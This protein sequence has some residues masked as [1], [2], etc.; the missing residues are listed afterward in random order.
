MLNWTLDD[1]DTA[2]EQTITTPKGV[3]FSISNRLAN[4][5]S[6]KR[7]R[8]A[9]VAA[10]HRFRNRRIRKNKRRGRNRTREQRHDRKCRTSPCKSLN[11]GGRRSVRNAHKDFRVCQMDDFR[12]IFFDT[13]SCPTS[14]DRASCTSSSTGTLGATE[15]IVTMRAKAVVQILAPA[16]LSLGGAA[17]EFVTFADTSVTHLV[18]PLR[19][20]CMGRSGPQSDAVDDSAHRCLR[21]PLQLC[22]GWNGIDGESSTGPV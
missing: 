22:R 13:S 9:G 2:A 18:F 8:A 14:N 21:G 20:G 7:P 17:G 3:A 6:R 4:H 16:M 15:I 19:G 10:A 1:A 11:T 5:L 12:K